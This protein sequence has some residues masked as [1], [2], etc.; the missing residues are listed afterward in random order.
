MP[1]KIR[2][3]G[4]RRQVWNGSAEK[5]IGGLRKDQLI[6]NKHG[7]IVSTRRHNRMKAK[8]DI[9]EHE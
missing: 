7:R 9:E 2:K 4:T 8:M 5:T 1:D 6:K 3:S